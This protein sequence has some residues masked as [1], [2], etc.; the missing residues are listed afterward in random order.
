V[1]PS[2]TSGRTLPSSGTD[3]VARS[4]ITPSVMNRLAQ[5]WTPLKHLF[6]RPRV[7][8]ARFSGLR[9][10]RSLSR[11]KSLLLQKVSNLSPER[12]DIGRFCEP[13]APY[14]HTPEA[15]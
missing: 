11:I 15:V 9:D 13:F 4:R 5:T 1:S 14:I 7:R 2:N 10:S 3:C 8:Y 6:A 12:I